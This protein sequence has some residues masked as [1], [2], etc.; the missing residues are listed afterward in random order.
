[1]AVKHELRHFTEEEFSTTR[2]EWEKRAGDAEFT[3]EYGLVFD[4]ADS[5]REYEQS[6]LVGQSLAYGIFSK[7]AVHAYAIVDVVSH[8]KGINSMTKLLKIYITPEYWD[9]EKHQS[10]I[11]DIFLCA[12][13]GT[14]ELSKQVS[15]RTVKLYG[16]STQLL[17]LL[18]SLHVYMN[19]N[20]KDLPGVTVTMQGRWLEIA[21]TK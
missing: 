10:Q 20:S 8:K 19:E 2:Q 15:A 13:I 18:H 9:V 5:H 17:S 7:R 12:I 21:T 3:S 14:V 16:R 4:W 11:R 6:F 1:M